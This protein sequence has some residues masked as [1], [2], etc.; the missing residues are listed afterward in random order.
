MCV[1][2]LVCMCVFWFVGVC[3]DVRCVCARTCVCVCVCVC[4]SGGLYVC[5][6]EDKWMELIK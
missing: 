4:V 2:V 3:E 5:T 6:C 1:G